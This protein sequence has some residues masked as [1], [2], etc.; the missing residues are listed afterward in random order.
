MKG[1]SEK[2][3]QRYAKQRNLRMSLLRKTKRI[4]YLN[5]NEM[6]VIDYRK[7]W[8]TVK[9]MLSNKLVSSDKITLVEDGKVI[10]DARRKL[11]KLIKEIQKQ[12]F[13]IPKIPV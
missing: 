13:K 6:N 2:D 4:Y 9:P 1:R 3:Q 7:F 8:K 10:T 12:I 11:L 5:F